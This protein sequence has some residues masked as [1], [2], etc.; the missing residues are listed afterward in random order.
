MQFTVSSPGPLSGS[1][2]LPG[3]LRLTLVL[4]SLGMFVEKPLTILN[5]STAPDVEK[6]RAFLARH[7]ASITDTEEGFTMRGTR[8]AGDVILDRDIPDAVIHCIATGAVF[9]AKTVKII[10]GETARAQYVRPLIKRLASVGL[11]TDHVTA[12]G[13][14]V[15]IRRCECAAPGLV[16][17]HSQWAFE[18]IIT[19]ALAGR[20]SV[21]VSLNSGAVSPSEKVLGEFGC[22]L[23]PVSETGDTQIELERR[24]ARISGDKTRG[25]VTVQWAEKPGEVRVEIPGDS[26]LAAAVA[27]LAAVLQRSS[28]IIEKVVWDTGRR[29]FF[30]TLR[31]M[32]ARVIPD[33]EKNGRL[34]DI[35]DIRVDWSRLDGVH[36][37][38]EQAQTMTDELLILA[39]VATAAP[40]ETVISDITDA[41]G[42]GREAF[43]LL[44]RGLEKCGI[45]VGDFT[46][47]IVLRGGGELQGG[48]L[49]SGGKPDVALA[50]AVAGMTASSAVTIDGSGSDDYPV[51]EFLR[52]VRELS[53]RIL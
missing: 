20:S 7:G 36:V 35:A 5:P 34:L 26:T 49:D 19:A 47:G 43:K 13:D 42:V 28:V 40:G 1:I 51:S 37:T 9:C 25:I 31:R 11:G 46:E 48:V 8:L 3:D 15:V 24:M 22:T 21:T 14:D 23:S 10:D 50:L 33:S 52:L 32:K 6:L 44:A 27:G 53:G 16:T 2:I 18:V 38:P 12:D 4:M 45:R 41:P 17:V 39:S 29:G 30:D